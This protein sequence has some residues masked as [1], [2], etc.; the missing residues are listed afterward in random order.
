M[1]GTLANTG[2]ASAG[3]VGTAYAGVWA[4]LLV[5]TVVLA[6]VAIARLVPKKLT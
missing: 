3:L 1:Y 6:V 5:V 4:A 2:A